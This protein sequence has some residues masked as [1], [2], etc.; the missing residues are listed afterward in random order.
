[1]RFGRVIMP[2]VGVLLILVYTYAVLGMELLHD[3]LDPMTSATMGSDCAPYCP[4]FANV[5]LA[6]LTLFQLLIGAR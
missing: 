5:A 2:M 3:A 6:W 4:S 1:M